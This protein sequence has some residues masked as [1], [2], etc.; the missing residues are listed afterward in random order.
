MNCSKAQDLIMSHVEKTI[1]P[2]EAK[3]LFNHVNSCSACREMYLLMDEA[4]EIDDLEALTEAP[5]GFTEAIMNMVAKEAYVDAVAEAPASVTA[6]GSLALRILW[7]FSAII[8][9]V[10]LFVTL[11]PDVVT[12]LAGYNTAIDSM[13]Y[14]VNGL[15]DIIGVA[16]TNIIEAFSGGAVL[17]GTLG[18]FALV[19]VVIVG[20]LFFILSRQEKITKAW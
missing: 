15:S 13:L 4:A 5:E 17:T 2:K 6:G 12:N 9:G 16:V 18:Y 11:N 8:L 14:A 3:S 19:F 20:I 10:L 1:N 7:G